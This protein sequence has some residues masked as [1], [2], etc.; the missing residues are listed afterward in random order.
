MHALLST[1]KATAAGQG[2]L[3]FLSG[4]AGIGR[5]RTALELT[6]V[7]CSQGAHVLIGGGIEEAGAPPFWQ[8]SPSGPC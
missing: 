7:A 5:T 3:V 1:L 4:E 2:L 8:A 6:T